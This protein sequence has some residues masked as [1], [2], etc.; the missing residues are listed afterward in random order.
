MSTIKDIRSPWRDRY[1]PASFRGAQ[2]HLDRDARASGRR[3]VLHEYPKR[4]VPYTEDMGRAARRFSI[5]GYLIGPDYLDK[6]D[7]L[8]DALEEDGSGTLRLPLAYRRGDIKVI[9]TTYQVFESR[10]RGGICYVEME[11]TEAGSATNRTEASNTSTV[12]SAAAAV[13]TAQAQ[14][15]PSQSPQAV[16]DET[17]F[18]V[19]LHALVPQLPTL[20]ITVNFDLAPI[21]GL[22][23]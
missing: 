16:T 22:L 17:K 14:Q 7:R 19:D 18:Y 21:V 3:S 9:C 6:K 13:E 5:T 15:D 4:N 10:E 11:F 2:F 8:I 20:P 12:S 23:R 1:V